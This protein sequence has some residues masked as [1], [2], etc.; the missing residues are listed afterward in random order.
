YLCKFC[1][2]LLIIQ[3][4]IT[5]HLCTVCKVA[6]IDTYL[7]H[8][9]GSKQ[10]C[11]WVKMHVS[12]QWDVKSPCTYATFDILKINRFTPALG[13]NPYQSR[14]CRCNAY[15]LCSSCLSVQRIGGSH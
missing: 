14:S 10:C 1:S 11:I 3:L 8:S 7:L 12:R 2:I 9:L 6:R 15:A 13:S 5:K 4:Y